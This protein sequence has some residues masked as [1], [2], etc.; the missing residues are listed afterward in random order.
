[1]TNAPESFPASVNVSVLF[2]VGTDYQPRAWRSPMDPTAGFATVDVGPHL[3]MSCSDPRALLELADALR[4][5]AGL[6]ADLLAGGGEA[7]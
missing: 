4:T 6:L 7:R 5:A 1:M 2:Y 3:R